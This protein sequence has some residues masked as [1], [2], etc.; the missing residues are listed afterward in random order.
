MFPDLVHV[1]AKNRSSLLSTA[2]ERMS[3]DWVYLLLK[4]GVNPSLGQSRYRLEEDS[5]VV[6]LTP[7]QA[8][9]RQNRT[10]VCLELILRGASVKPMSGP[11]PAEIA[12]SNKNRVLILKLDEL[13]PED[14]SSCG[15]DL[16]AL[17]MACQIFAP[18]TRDSSQN[19]L[20]S[21]FGAWRPSVSDPDQA[22]LNWMA[23]VERVIQC[24]ARYAG[25]RYLDFSRW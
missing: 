1:P 18:R 10:R 20:H 17:G 16:T 14:L 15:S 22:A 13:G 3:D 9:F 12:V 2:V 4:A 7:L 21:C 23:E 19:S 25:S 5:P 24:L 8:A 11:S 6:L